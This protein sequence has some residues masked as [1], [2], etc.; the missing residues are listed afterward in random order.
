MPLPGCDRDRDD[1]VMKILIAFASRHGATSEIAER[2]A[3]R[4]ADAGH[5]VDL[6]EAEP[7]RWTDDEHDAYVIGSAVYYGRW[8]RAAHRFLDENAGVLRGRP[9]WLFSSGPAG[10]PDRVAV[11]AHEV[12]QLIRISGARSHRVFGGRLDEI[13]LSLVERAVT[14]V[15]HASPGDFRDWDEIDAWAA[16]IASAMATDQPASPASSAAEGSSQR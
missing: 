1:D 5:T 8:L 3:E 15:V 9:V 16:E 11:T 13:G 6:I 2:L 12:D 14:H 10:E 7:G 4:L